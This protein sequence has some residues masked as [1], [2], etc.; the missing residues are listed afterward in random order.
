[1][2]VFNF[3]FSRTFIVRPLFSITETLKTVVQGGTTNLG[4]RIDIKNKNETGIVARFF[5]STFEN[6]GGLV[7][8]IKDKTEALT[9]IGVELSSSISETATASNEISSNIDNMKILV[10]KTEQGADTAVKTVGEIRNNIDYLNKMIEKQAENVNMSS[11]AIEE[12][13]ANIHSVTQTLFA[14]TKNVNILA[15][16]SENGRVGL[17]AVAEAIQEIARDSE[18]LMEIN[19]V[20]ENIAS[21]TNLLSM[22]AAIEAAHAGEAGKGF[23]VVADEIRKLAESSGEQ[24]K[25]TTTMLKKIKTSIDNITKSSDE[26]LARFEAIDTGVKT[27]SQQEQSIL[28]AMEEQETGGKQILESVSLLNE[29]TSSV[30]TSSQDMTQAS[31]SLVME[32][33]ELQT[34]SMKATR[35][36]EDMAKGVND[37]N[38]AINH[39]NSTGIENKANIDALKQEMMKFINE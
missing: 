21:Q 7:G 12:M 6:I 5:N 36:M 20:M 33:G 10:N 4:K 9:T 28:H 37:I 19:S 31:R 14:N 8:I 15:E 35:G 17:Q 16:A 24:S 34:L 30:R 18:G 3:I 23:A 27:V 26:V 22:N 32:A 25:T 39:I 11:S 29:I 13:T 38:T 1:M 2:A